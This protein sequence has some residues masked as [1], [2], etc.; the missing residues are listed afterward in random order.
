M[1]NNHLRNQRKRENRRRMD[2][3]LQENAWEPEPA[4]PVVREANG[5]VLG[6]QGV[7]GNE[8]T[9]APVEGEVKKKKTRKPR[10]R[11]RH[12]AADAESPAESPTDAD[13]D[14]DN[15]GPPGSVMATDDVD[16]GQ[17]LQET[18]D[19][20]NNDPRVKYIQEQ[21][22]RQLA[23]L[24]EDLAS[25]DAAAKDHK[26][27]VKKLEDDLA[28]CKDELRKSNTAYN[29]SD[30]MCAENWVLLENEKNAFKKYREEH[31][32][33]IKAAPANF[34]AL[35][36]AKKAI[37]DITSE[38]KDI[39]AAGN[40]LKAE[41]DALLGENAELRTRNE[42]L[43]AEDVTNKE[44]IEANAETNDR[45]EEEISHVH[46]AFEY[47]FSDMAKDL[48]IDEKFAYAREQQQK[49]TLATRLAS[50]ATLH[51]ELEGT[52][53]P[54]PYEA[55]T[56]SKISS[57]ET[58]PVAAVPTVVPAVVAKK[59]LSFSSISSAHTPPVSLPA[60]A[61]KKPMSFSGITTVETA[62]LTA[63]PANTPLDTK[64]KPMSFSGIT[65]ISTSPV[66]AEPSSANEKPEVITK[67]IEVY[68]PYDRLVDRPVYP[69]WFLLPVSLGVLAV[70]GLSAALWRERMIWVTANDTAYQR[71]FGVYQE[72]WP[73]WIGLGVKELVLPMF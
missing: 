49:A 29:V 20:F 51:D 9:D 37:T 41:N 11:K 31:D 50:E 45:L 15:Q 58:V 40:E 24:E 55:F 32:E 56:F 43:E 47:T 7:D 19:A 10:T 2:N 28:V 12:D 36:E 42:H 35:A 70:L 22:Q 60:T 17:G 67:I 6:A 44:L 48:T 68:K 63:A 61:A 25:R 33:T 64:K 14:A 3:T 4:W 8:G 59:P 62:P 30:K 1:T 71:L 65:S 16:A 69:W 26:A 38:M 21:N 73:E 18:A 39:S 5:E 23:A 27:A 66:A 34:A 46:A 72:T 53:E 52:P 57:V 13:A 54:V